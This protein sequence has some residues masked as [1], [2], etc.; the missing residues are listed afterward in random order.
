MDNAIA[1]VSLALA[2]AA[3]FEADLVALMPQLRIFSRSVCRNATLAEDMAQQTLM[4]AWRAQAGFTAGTSL[5]SWLFTILRNQFFSH[6]RRAWRDARW[7]SEFG[8]RIPAAPD[9]QGWAVD[10]CDATRAIGVLSRRQREAL[11]L[12]AAGGLSFGDAAKFCGT[13]IGTV[14]SRVTRARIGLS[15]ILEDGTSLPPREPRRVASAAGDILA[16]LSALKPVAALAAG[17]A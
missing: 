16:Q 1:R 7:D 9:E 6:Q 3:P 14:K 13:P 12:V 11:L 15:R 5:K 2:P 17:H 10:L 4:H 8:E